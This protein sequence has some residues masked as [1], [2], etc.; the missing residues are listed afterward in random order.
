MRE[1]LLPTHNHVT[2][3]PQTRCTDADA[4]NGRTK[5]ENRPPVQR[6]HGARAAH[7]P[8]VFSLSTDR[9]F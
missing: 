4:Q 5:A 2:D 8:V 3:R 6:V 7:T 9:T 1:H